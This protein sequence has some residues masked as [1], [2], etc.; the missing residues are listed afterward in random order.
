MFGGTARYVTDARQHHLVDDSS[1]LLLNKGHNYEFE[2][3]STVP[4][5][6]F[7]IFFPADL[8]PAVAHQSVL[9][10]ESCLENEISRCKE[11]N[12]Y[13][14]L[15]P[16]EGAVSQRILRIRSALLLM[17]LDDARL[18]EELI[19]LA[20]DLISENKNIERKIAELPYAKYKTRSELF[21]RIH[22]A[23]DHIHAHYSDPF[24]LT[25][26]AR[27]ASMSPFHFLRSFSQI[28]G[29]TPLTYLQRVRL[30]QATGLLRQTK[31]PISEVAFRVGY[32]SLASFSTLFKKHYRIAP[33]EYRRVTN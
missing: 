22:V 2:K 10:D 30:Q 23:R 7:C 16:H 4:I 29:E 24:S 19:L 5:E 11:F 33:S 12:H 26:T 6:T 28:I 31:L 3:R 25:E 9:T 17:H 14:Y 21:R 18:E 32:Q 20:F 1:F 8:V 13:E 27:V 15:R